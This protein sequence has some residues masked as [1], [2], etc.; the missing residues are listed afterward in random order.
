[1]HGVLAVPELNRVYASATATDEVV[2]IDSSTLK[3]VARVPVGKYPDG[4]AYAPEVGVI[5][6]FVLNLALFV[7]N[8]AL[9]LKAFTG[10]ACRS[11]PATVGRL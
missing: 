6:L 9:F 5:V 7:L 1:M 4:I 11:T 10:K 3:I 8:L 2:T